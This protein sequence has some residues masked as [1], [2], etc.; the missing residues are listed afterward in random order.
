MWIVLVVIYNTLNGDMA[1]VNRSFDSQVACQK[2]AKQFE[3][4]ETMQS[5]CIKKRTLSN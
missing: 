3:A 2:Y 4:T 5:V 1:V